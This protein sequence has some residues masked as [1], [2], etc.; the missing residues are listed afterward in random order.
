M[1]KKLCPRVRILKCSLSVGW[2]SSCHFLENLAALG[3][4]F[5]PRTAKM[6]ISGSRHKLLCGSVS[7][8]PLV[9]LFENYTF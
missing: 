8:A 3:G 7:C 5:Y 2:T 1:Q 9:E 6:I 4:S